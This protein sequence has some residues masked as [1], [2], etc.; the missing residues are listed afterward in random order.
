MHKIEN[1]T[2]SVLYSDDIYVLLISESSG[3]SSYKTYCTA[4]CT[5]SAIT[6]TFFMNVLKAVKQLS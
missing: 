3:G 1:E 5:A 6:F 2:N 4:L